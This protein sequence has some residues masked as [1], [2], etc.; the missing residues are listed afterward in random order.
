M[1]FPIENSLGIPRSEMPQIDESD[2]PQF[3]INLKNEGID[4]SFQVFPASRL[5]PTQS[6]VNHDKINDEPDLLKPFIV[7]SDFRILDGHH[8]LY[9]IL[10]Q[11][12][13]NVV[14]CWYVDLNMLEL[15]QFARRFSGSSYKEIHEAKKKKG[16]KLMN[17][18]DLKKLLKMEETQPQ[19]NGQGI[20]Q[21]GMKTI[22][23]DKKP[24]KKKKKLRE[25][26]AEGETEVQKLRDKQDREKEDLQKKQEDEVLGAKEQDLRNKLEA[27]RREREAKQDEQ[28]RKQS[29]KEASEEGTDETVKLRKDVVPG[30]NQ[31]TEEPLKTFR[32]FLNK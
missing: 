16:K 8:R 23:A 13:N 14:N 19:D 18:K 30:Q 25:D 29:M 15:L 31:E 5:K 2:I 20:Y 17:F 7:S 11:N 24:P 22:F 10:R 9:S 6:E 4:V 26:E 28:E 12:R 27:Q 1:Y 32:E 3:I 21:S